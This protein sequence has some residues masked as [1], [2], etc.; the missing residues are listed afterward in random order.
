MSPTG[1]T[2]RSTRRSRPRRRRPWTWPSADLPGPRT[3]RGCG[4]AAP[5]CSP[6]A[7]RA[8]PARR[9]KRPGFHRPHLGRREPGAEAARQPAPARQ[10]AVRPPG[11]P[12]GRNAALD[13]L[14]LGSCC[15]PSPSPAVS[16]RLA[17]G[18]DPAERRCVAG[19]VL[20][21]PPGVHYP[22]DTIAGTASG[23]GAGACGG[24][25]PGAATLGV[26]D[27]QGPTG[28]LAPESSEVCDDG[29]LAQRGPSSDDTSRHDR[30]E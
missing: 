2:R 9:G 7:R 30:R 28:G 5:P 26:V 22:S 23:V 16:V 20:A 19:C 24:S 12:P 11:H 4:S 6:Q 14:A 18:R 15:R 3:I 10:A 8:R 1:S 17:A 25:R 29:S 27:V 21:C 13:V